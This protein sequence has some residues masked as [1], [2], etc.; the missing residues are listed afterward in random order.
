MLHLNIF[1]STLAV[2]SSFTHQPPTSTI[3][4]R[5][6]ALP[7]YRQNLSTLHAAKRRGGAMA[8][9]KNQSIQSED[10]ITSSDDSSSDNK[11]FGQMTEDDDSTISKSDSIYSMPPL[12]DL[13]FGY[14][15]YDE[16]VDF[17]L[18][19]HD[20]YAKHSSTKEPLRILE[21]A[22]GPARHSLSALSEHLSSEVDSVVAL[23]RS[24]EM[25]DYGVENADYELGVPGGRRDD[26]VYVNGDMRSVGDS[27]NT[28]FDTAWLLLGSASHLLT[29]NDV[30]ACLSSVNSV[31][32]SGGTVV[33]ELP[34]PRETFS[35]GECTR[36]G[37]TV[38]LVEDDMDGDG[39]E[40]EY[41]EL[42][43]V[44]G[45]EG[46]DFDPVLQIRHFTVGLELTVNNIEDI[47]KDEATS[48]LFLQM[49]KE[50][51]TKVKE[52]VP[53]RL[54]TL[55]EIDALARCAGFELIAKYGALAEDVSI[56]DED[57]AF[58]MVCVLT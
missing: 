22:A 55:Q 27:T 28:S 8:R 58:R 31:L 19:A 46:D 12:Y 1:L 7:S 40:K 39:E 49:S 25:V 30:I 23:D 32:K 16:E 33:I 13:A 52:I 15:N 20:K 43:I 47:P 41:G 10:D 26:F 5:S 21:L 53:M 36:N 44:W 34:H 48:P 37:W 42:N 3:L 6:S 4:C 45:E 50:G 35:M 2:V 18:D 38:P 17:L 24:Q 54:F 57:G 9:R 56:E 14:R 51:K 11:G 29:N